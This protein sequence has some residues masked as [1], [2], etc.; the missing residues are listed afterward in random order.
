MKVDLFEAAPKSFFATP[1]R[2]FAAKKISPL[3]LLREIAKN[4]VLDSWPQPSDESPLRN[5]LSVSA[6]MQ[7]QS[8]SAGKQIPPLTRVDLAQ[9]TV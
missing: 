8:R 9:I 4:T 2:C 6:P 3:V 7:W 5:L 1:F